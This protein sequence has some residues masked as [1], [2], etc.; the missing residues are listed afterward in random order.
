M[1]SSN[2]GSTR[3]SKFDVLSAASSALKTPSRF[4]RSWIPSSEAVVVVEFSGADIRWE[5]EG[6]VSDS[7][8]DSRE[9][10]FSGSSAI[11]LQQLSNHIT[12]MSSLNLP[13]GLSFADHEFRVKYTLLEI[14]TSRREVSASRGCL[15]CFEEWSI[16]PSCFNLWLI[17]QHI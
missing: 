2:S 7:P 10:D 4:W 11:P 14:T 6:P 1:L 9:S 12:D 17:S 15:A 3:L 8:E 16:R 5:A 13:G